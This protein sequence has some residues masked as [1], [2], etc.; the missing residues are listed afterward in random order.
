MGIRVE[1]N[2]GFYLEKK[3]IFHVLK[4]NYQEI[5]DHAENISIERLKEYKKECKSKNELFSNIS[6]SLL[7]MEEKDIKI[8][9]FI[10]TIFYGDKEEGILLTNIDL[11]RTGRRDDLIDYYEGRGMP[12]FKI[13]NLK[14]PIYPLISYVCVKTPILTKESSEDIK[15]SIRNKKREGKLSIGDKVIFNDMLDIFIEGEDSVSNKN[16]EERVMRLVYPDDNKNKYFHPYVDELIYW[17]C[18]E[19]G[20]LKE[21]LSYID[22]IQYLEP[23]IITT[24]N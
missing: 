6:L 14:M 7:I 2:I 16:Y 12:D 18:L 13:D 9:D 20:V 22:F 17:V 23:S 3:D 21:G 8:S 19:I 11:K 1:K 10:N 5:I 4:S 15:D 24:W